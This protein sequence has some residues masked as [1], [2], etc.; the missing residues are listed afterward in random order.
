M[1]VDDDAVVDV[2]SGCFGQCRVRGDARTNHDRVGV[3]VDLGQL[4]AQHRQER[5][6][7]SLDYRDLTAC[8]ARGGGFKP[9]GVWSR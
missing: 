8:G 5:Q 6:F 7:G 9:Q 1:C 2:Q 3:G 4:A